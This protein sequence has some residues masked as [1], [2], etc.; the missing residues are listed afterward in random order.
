MTEEQTTLEETESKTEEETQETVPDTGYPIDLMTIGEV[1][2]ASFSLYVQPN[3]PKG[4]TDAV[5]M[6]I[7]YAEKATGHKLVI[8]EDAPAEHAIV[9]GKTDY[10]TDALKAAREQVE[11]DGYAFL[12]ENG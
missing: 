8:H 11:N 6:L 10:D 7:E 4:I 2:F 5:E 1:P 12:E 9:I 3:A